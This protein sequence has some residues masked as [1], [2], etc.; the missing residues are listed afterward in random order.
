MSKSNFDD[1]LNK[2]TSKVKSKE[3]H[4]LIKKELS[5]HLKE[6]SQSFQRRDFSK[7]EADEKAVQ[8]MGNPF[9]L[10]EN[11][12]R[13]HRPKLDWVLLLLFGIIAAISFLP[14]SGWTFENEAIPDNYFVT[15]QAI[16]LSLSILVLVAFLFLDYRKLLRFWPYL[17]CFGFILLLYTYFL[18]VM[19][20]GA[21]NHIEVSG[22]VINSTH[23]TLF[24]FFLAWIGILYRINTFKSWKKQMLLFFLF[25]IPIIFYMMLPNFTLT[26]MYISCVCIMFCFSKVHKS[27]AIK[28]ITTS[29]G[30]G[31]I[32][33]VPLLFTP[34]GSHFFSERLSAFLYPEKDP[35]GYGWVYMVLKNAYSQAGWFGNGFTNDTF[36]QNLPDIFTDFVFPYLVY[37]FGWV[38]G[39]FLCLLLLFFIGRISTNAFKTKDL[40]GRLLVI[41]G[42]SLISVPTIWNIFMGLGL[43]PLVSFSLPF[44]S[45]GGSMLL[46]NSAIL[47]L[48]LSVYRRKDI[49]QTYSYIK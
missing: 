17:Y 41:G 47:G 39:I 49:I 32:L 45:Y 16:W 37:S 19:K 30:T 25:W 15:R 3:A 44:I 27:L 35:G 33:L 28:I 46:F 5:Y 10:G 4:I 21:M 9:N 31:I 38:F 13:I 20:M 1:F 14:V 26:I 7:D 40:F 2:V 12:N 29:V 11:L 36:I 23:C 48:I 8:E 6:L 43:L 18:G 34:R 42:A 22:V 24:L